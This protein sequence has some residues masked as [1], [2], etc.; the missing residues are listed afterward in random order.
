PVVTAA[1]PALTRPRVA[2]IVVTL[3]LLSFLWTFGLPRELPT[4]SLPVIH[5]DAP[6]VEKP[7]AV[8][9]AWPH[10][11]STSS[12]NVALNATSTGEGASASPAKETGPTNPCKQ[13]KGASD[14]M[15][16]VKTSKAE[17]DRKL[18][19]HLETLLTCVPNFA[20]FSDHSGEI[21]GHKIYDAL[22]DINPDIRKNHEEFNDYQKIVD[23]PKDAVKEVNKDLDKWKILPMVYKA[24]KLRPYAKF[25]FFIEVDTSLSWTN[26]LQWVDRLDYRIPY[27]S[28]APMFLG[29]VKFARRGSGIMLSYGAMNQ[30][31]KSYEERY[32]SEWEPRVGRECCGDMVLATALTEAHVEFYSSFPLIQGE[33]PSSLD[34]TDK[35]WCAPVVTWHHMAVDDIKSIWGHQKKWS[36]EKG[37]EVPYLFRNAFNDSV[38]QQ[39]A[40]QKE[41]WDNFGSDTKIVKGALPKEE[42]KPKEGDDEKKKEKG[43]EK[44]EPGNNIEDIPDH[45]VVINAAADSAM[46][47]KDLCSKTEDCIQWKYLAITKDAGKGSE[48]HLSKTIRLG[49]KAKKS[50]DAMWTSGWMEEKIKKFSDEHRCEEVKW[51]FNQ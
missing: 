3:S 42:E 16:I 21:S 47:C 31:A 2:I 48:C 49:A 41:E 39:L 33:T 9:G 5:H 12:V 22:A 14:V 24:H 17:L 7:A 15:I 45:G 38:Q 19:T 44:N 50:G 40:D 29:D 34:W 32:T 10:A 37:W 13:V 11:Q 30:Y 4:P 20:I 26:A 25:Y 1:M 18:S 35:N 43:D 27:Y 23:H 8:T 36:E 51:G 6:S 46:A 28:G